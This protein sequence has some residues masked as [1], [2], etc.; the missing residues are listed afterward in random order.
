MSVAQR[1]Q[2][3]ALEAEEA[4]E[5]LVGTQRLAEERLQARRAELAA[6]GVLPSIGDTIGDTTTEASS[7]PP[8]PVPPPRP[9]VGASYF[10]TATYA[11]VPAQQLVMTSPTW[12]QML[13]CKKRWNYDADAE[14]AVG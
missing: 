4:S 10:T 11:L 7:A 5:R 14:S 2:G 6:R 9:S 13:K 3:E 12:T 8:H 1:R